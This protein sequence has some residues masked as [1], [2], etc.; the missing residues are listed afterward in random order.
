MAGGGRDQLGPIERLTRILL[1]LEGNEPH[2]VPLATLVDVADFR[3]DHETAT[4]QLYREIK[5]L[6]A[7]GWD[8]RNVATPGR[9]AIYRVFARDNRLRMH[10]SLEQRAELARAAIAAGDPS[11]T[12][13]V[14]V[15]V[16]WSQ[17]AASPDPTSPDHL[18]AVIHA[19]AH[20]CL[21]RFVYKQRPRAVHPHVVTAGVSGWYLAGN[22]VGDDVVVKRFVVARMSD[23]TVDA[24]GTAQAP[25]PHGR[26][27]IDPLSWQVDPPVDVVIDTT[28][29][30][31]PRVE[32]MLG[33]PSAVETRPST[34]ETPTSTDGA[35]TPTVR[36]TIPVTHRAAFRW[37]LY[38]LGTRVRLIGP[39]DVRAEVLAEL[40]AMADGSA[41]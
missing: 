30:H 2:G 37:R 4:R 24:P 11:F 21:V 31:R 15:D 7:A 5:N 29:D 41:A 28:T 25:A 35:G 34:D 32:E 16:P 10:F 19:A 6:N 26:T 3:G 23:V 27:S 12:E 9:A 13:T 8:I 20:H 1:V 14:G 33:A 36:L 40:A 17:R 39:D 18:D 22:E 38:E